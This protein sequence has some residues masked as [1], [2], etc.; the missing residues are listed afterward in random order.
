[1]VLAATL[2]VNC[3]TARL[4]Q[5]LVRIHRIFPFVWTGANLVVERASRIC[6]CAA[7][8]HSPGRDEEHDRERGEDEPVGAGGRG[9]RVAERREQR[10]PELR[11]AVREDSSRAEVVTDGLEGPARRHHHAERGAGLR[12]E[13]HGQDRTREQHRGK[14][15]HRQ[16]ERRLRDVSD[17]RRT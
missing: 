13:V 6:A 1:M 11:A 5:S 2:I 8:E 10:R 17:R 14:A 15:Q 7:Y 16:R 3:V 4:Q 9:A 12:H